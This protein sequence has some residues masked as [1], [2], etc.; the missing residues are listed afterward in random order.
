MLIHRDKWGPSRRGG[1]GI[2]K[3]EKAL[4]CPLYEK[5]VT[6]ILTA[7]NTV[8]GYCYIRYS[9]SVVIVS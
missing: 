5:E 4:W 9:F 7:Y 6:S 1:G 2:V 3:M 8:V